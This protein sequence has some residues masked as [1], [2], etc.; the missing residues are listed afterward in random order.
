[1]VAKGISLPQ[2]GQR[3]LSMPK[4]IVPPHLKH[5]AVLVRR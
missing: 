3:Q 1:M 2:S 4:R 5:S